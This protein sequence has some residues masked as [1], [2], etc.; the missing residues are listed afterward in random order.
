MEQVTLT[1]TRESV[2]EELEKVLRLALDL[3]ASVPG[4][5]DAVA[6][7]HLHALLLRAVVATCPSI[8]TLTVDPSQL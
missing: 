5:E 3:V 4:A 2:L 6:K 8:I 1:V 7:L